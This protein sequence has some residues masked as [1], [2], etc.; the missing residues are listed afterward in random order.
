MA[1]DENEIPE[2]P[3]EWMTEAKRHFP[4]YLT[5]TRDR[6]GTTEYTCTRCNGTGTVKPLERTQT[7][8]DRAILQMRH[9]ET[10]TCPLCGT[11]AQAL[12]RRMVSMGR[13]VRFSLPFAF[14][15]RLTPERLLIRVFWL[16]HLWD[17]DERQFYYY[18]YE[19][20][21][22]YLAP[23][24]GRLAVFSHFAG[25]YGIR[26][27]VDDVPYGTVMIGD[28]NLADTFLKY[29]SYDLYRAETH[30]P[31]YIRY[32]CYY[33]RY[34]L[35]EQLVKA[36]YS[37]FVCD[38]VSLN[39]PNASVIDFTAPSVK[40]AF[41]VRIEDLRRRKSV[42]VYDTCQLM[43][44]TAKFRRYGAK[45]FDKAL[46]YKKN[47]MTGGVKSEA[48]LIHRL[49]GATYEQMHAYLC[50]QRGG[51]RLTEMYRF[52][53]DY[54]EQAQ[55]LEA[56]T[57]DSGFLFPRD[58]MAA[59]DRIADLYNTK[60]EAERLEKEKELMKKSA[61]LTK[62]LRERYGYEDEHYTIVLPRTMGDIIY[63]G[64]ELRHCVGGYA[65]RHF[66]GATVIVFVRREEAVKTPYF[67]VEFDPT[68]RLIRQIHGF[69]NCNPDKELQAFADAWQK[70]VLRRLDNE[71]KHKKR[72]QTNKGTRITA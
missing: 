5:F 16:H 1:N 27:R 57:T 26:E 14:F 45:A 49:T 39:K 33:A 30:D 65:R 24:V 72:K 59:H 10:V 44:L 18:T 12:N 7:P 21:R 63:E 4:A 64:K 47:I 23:G 46:F 70:E 61:A 52:Y 32:L 42:F 41:K 17:G 71:Q 25:E 67:T 51:Y 50:R 40:A 29:N 9:N 28:T 58:F 60:L 34:P 8:A 43:R 66:E 37:D 2:I 36:G 15:F 19:P 13:T 53:K 6:C 35:I 31:C 11:Q 48:D 54:L 20:A 62:R 56:F 3:E 38:L 68:T 69:A 55:K 22:Y